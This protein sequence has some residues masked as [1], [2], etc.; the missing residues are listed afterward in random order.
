MKIKLVQILAIA[1]I[2]L[3]FLLTKQFSIIPIIFLAVSVLVDFFTNLRSGIKNLLYF[4]SA[5]S[6]FMPFFS[7]FL[8]YLP[9]SVF[10]LLLANKGFI[11]NYVLGFTFSFIPSISIYLISTYLSIR[12]SLPLIW[13]PPPGDSWSGDDGSCRSSNRVSISRWM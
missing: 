7:M 11:K 10:G 6:A 12:L 1:Y 5:I 8:V 13:M 2:A 4:L 9:F 3:F